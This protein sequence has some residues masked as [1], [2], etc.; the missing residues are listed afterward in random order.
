MQTDVKRRRKGGPAAVDDKGGAAA[1]P[2]GRSGRAVTTDGLIVAAIPESYNNQLTVV[3]R[4]L[5]SPQAE[6]LMVAFENIREGLVM[7][8][9][10]ERLVMMNPRYAEMYAIP[11]DL[12]KPGVRFAELLDY[13]G[14]VGLLD[15]EDNLTARRDVASRDTA[16]CVRLHLCDG[17]VY[18]LNEQPLPGGGWVSTHDDITARVRAEERILFLARHDALTGLENRASFHEG[19]SSHL[20]KATK[21]GTPNR[22]ALMM[23]D[24]DRF[25]AINDQLGHDRGD[26]VLSL[27]GR[28]VFRKLPHGTRVARLGGDE[29]AIILDVAD[30][31]MAR[32]VAAD[33]VA[34]ISEP[35]EFDT[36]TAEIGASL[37]IAYHPDHGDDVTTLMK[38]ADQALRAVKSRPAEAIL[39]YD[40]TLGDAETARDELINRLPGALDTG[41][42]ALHFQPIINAATGQCTSAEA[43]LR[44]RHPTLGMVAPDRVIELAEESRL[45]PRLGLWILKRAL[46]AASGWPR[47]IGVAVNLSAIQFREEGFAES[48]LAAIA[49]AGV[50]PERLELEL[51]ETLL[52]DDSAVATIKKLR[53][54]GVRFSL[55]DFGTG[56]ASMSYLLR[57]PF[58][59]V[60][61]DRSF[62]SSVDIR[63]DRR[64]IVEAIAGLAD[65]LGLEVVAEGVETE[66]ERRIVQSVGCG[67]LQGYL[68]GKPMPEADFRAFLD[69]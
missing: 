57:F 58:D 3:R 52:C 40:R 35:F 49:E 4:K 42:I 2:V 17:R 38:C 59:R 39:E 43:L 9:D 32:S 46:A 15:V 69:H 55:D 22:F 36:V 41:E 5:I 12:Q 24:L 47:H 8:D 37:G 61:I 62:V 27:I 11:P 64:I 18:E 68:F 54:Q 56:Y 67:F 14:R 66:G 6:R 25:K 13:W 51:T 1:P 63:T 19:L 53:Y 31:S 28:R 29:F 26:Q 34:A 45:M 20:A 10:D 65:R 48:V 33:V 23:F 7:Y 50:E 16:S 30:R 60:K 44:W 21:D